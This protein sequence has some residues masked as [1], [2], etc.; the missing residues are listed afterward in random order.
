MRGRG[1]SM[2]PKLK[3]E[4]EPSY[5]QSRMCGKCVAGRLSRLSIREKIPPRRLGFQRIEHSDGVQQHSLR[6][7]LLMTSS[8]MFH[9]CG[10]H[11]ICGLVRAVGFQLSNH[12]VHELRN[13]ICRP[14]IAVA[15]E[16]V[17]ERPEARPRQLPS[18]PPTLALV[19]EQPRTVKGT[20]RA[21]VRTR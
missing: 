10:E 4:S 1:Q 18:F 2:C 7:S 6:I 8:S 20:G 14:L 13:V 16:Q 19:P 21:L 15:E 11:R 9:S 5:H 3:F 17:E 12:L